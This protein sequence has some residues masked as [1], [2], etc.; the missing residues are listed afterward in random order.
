MANSGQAGAA[1][2]VKIRGVHS[3]ASNSAPIINVDGVRIYNLP[4]RAGWDSHQSTSP[5]PGHRPR[6]HRANRGREGR[7][8][9]H[10]VRYGG[11]RGRDPDLHEERADGR[12]PV[13]RRAERPAASAA[14]RFGAKNDPSNLFVDCNNHGADVRAGHVQRATARRATGTASTSR[15][16]PARPERALERARAAQR[17]LALRARRQRVDHVLP[18][19]QLQRPVGLP[20]DAAQQGRRAARQRFLRAHGQLYDPAEL[21]RTSGCTRAGPRT[22]TTPTASCSTS[23]AASAAISRAARATIA[24]AC[25]RPGPAARPWCA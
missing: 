5:A 3:V 20:A 14:P 7:R 18:V 24:P 21:A 17:A 16:R 8:R 23:A 19:R 13:E 1:S 15:T 9:H 25:R 6:G 4:T 11:G 12:H 10:A 2:T 22:A